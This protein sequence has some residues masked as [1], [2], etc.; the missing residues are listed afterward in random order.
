MTDRRDWQRLVRELTT[1][2]TQ[3]ETERDKARAEGR[4]DDAAEL[5]RRVL[6]KQAAITKLIQE[7]HGRS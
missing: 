5:S 2:R 1:Q 7:N 3:L 6:Q 4:K